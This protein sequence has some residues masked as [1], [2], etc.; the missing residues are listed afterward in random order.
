MSGGGDDGSK[1]VK[2][3]QQHEKRMREQRNRAIQ[4]LNILFGVGDTPES[5]G[6]APEKPVK[7]GPAAQPGGTAWPGN[8]PSL[9]GFS[10]GAGVNPGQ[11]VWPNIAPIGGTPLDPRMRE[12]NQQLKAYEQYFQDLERAQSVAANR[13]AREGIYNTIRD[14][15]R[16]HHQHFLDRDFDD[17]LRN[18]KFELARRGHLGGSMELDQRDRSQQLFDEGLLSIANLGDQAANQARSSDEQA[19]LHA[20]RDINA[21]VDASTAIQGALSQIDL[22]ASQAAAQGQGQVLGNVFQ[23]LAYLYNM[24]RHNDAMNRA[25]QQRRGGFTPSSGVSA[26]SGFS[27]NIT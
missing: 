13:E 2:Q 12:Y 17:T 7:P 14:D 26:G 25:M 23:N 16:G 19:R 8:V 3:Q 27:G 10:F 9:A 6:P 1:A 20:I 21:D 15:V 24:Q 18:L 4:E 11:G 5:L 22:N